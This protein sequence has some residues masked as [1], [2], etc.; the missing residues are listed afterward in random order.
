MSHNITE[1]DIQIGTEMGWHNLTTIRN[2]ISLTEIPELRYDMATTP[3][4]IETAAGKFETDFKQIYSLDD[5]MP[6]GNPV[7]SKYQLISNNQVFDMVQDA[8]S[9]FKHE[10]VS[11]GSVASRS[12]V[13]V[14][15]SLKENEVI[16]A[17]TRATKPMLNIMFG[18]GGNK[19]LIAKSGFVTVVCNNTFDMAMAEKSDFQLKLK[20]CKNAADKLDGMSEAIDKHYGIVSEFKLALDGM[21]AKSCDETRA[22]R[23][24]AGILGNGEKMSTRTVN[25]VD[26]VVQLY[27]GGAGN[28]GKTVADLFNGFTDYYSHE[29]SGNTGNSWK[30]FMSSEFGSA[31]TAKREVFNVL[32]DDNT[33][34]EVAAR[35]AKSLELTM[36]N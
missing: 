12:L 33:L 24:A 30:Q 9:G 25:T 1:R 11:V 5:N 28:K 20:H 29:S 35:G 7:G 36:A 15:V 23:L 10:I 19:P 31:S 6:V 3:L 26:R 21:H 13:F 16:K 34:K 4:F 17:A 2:P 18:H 8:L 27:K 14:S 32:N 22:T